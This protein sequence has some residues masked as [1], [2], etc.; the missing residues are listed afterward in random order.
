MKTARTFRHGEHDN[1]PT[2]CRTGDDYGG[3][4]YC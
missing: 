1:E 4:A 3:V 2:D